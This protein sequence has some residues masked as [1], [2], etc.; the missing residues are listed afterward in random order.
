MSKPQ[1]CEVFYCT[2]DAVGTVRLAAPGAKAVTW[3][4]CGR[5]LARVGFV[6]MSTEG[7]P[8]PEVTS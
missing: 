3:H 7:A 1:E 2:K 4:V 5:H 6:L 8:E